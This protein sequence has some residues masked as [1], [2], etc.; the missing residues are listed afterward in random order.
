MEA[1]RRFQYT[2]EKIRLGGGLVMEI[3]VV[4]SGSSGNCYRISDGSTPLLLE[5]GLPF[6]E[7]RRALNF[8]V[9]ELAG[10]LVSHDHGDHAKAAKDVLKAG[11]DV[12]ASQ[13]T[14]EALGLAGHRLHP[15]RAKEQFSIGPWSVL[16]FE[17][18]HDAV[19]P[20]G[21]QLTCGRERLVY[22]TDSAYCRY[23]FRGMT[24]LMLEINYDLTI[25]KEN[26]KAGLVDREVK[27]RVLHSHMSLDTAKAFLRANDL[28][29]VQAIWLLHLSDGN[30]DAE[31]F[32][33]TVAQITGKP[34]YVA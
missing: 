4:A 28:S 21:F 26:V 27:R 29:R 31:M 7:I 5:A 32:K 15:I 23:V 24:H 16:P 3:Q 20:L 25:L 6:A 8:R 2:A 14:I 11:V 18:V 10:C 1:G 19:E 9:S 33:R 13:G 30:S 12:Y 17:T 34:V 22:I